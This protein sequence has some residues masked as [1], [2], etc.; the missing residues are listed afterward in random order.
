MNSKYFR[1]RTFKEYLVLPFKLLYRMLTFDYIWFINTLIMKSKL[2]YCGKDVLLK[3]GVIIEG[4]QFVSIG[5]K[6]QIGNYS[7]LKGGGN[8]QIGEWCQIASFVIIAT[9]NHNIDG[10]LYY[11]N[12]TCKDII[13]GNNVW[14]ASNAIILPGVKIGN[15]SVVAAGSVVSKNV[16]DNTVVGGVPAIKI[17]KVPEKNSD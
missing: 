15:N 4:S 5:Y 16:P 3:K 8:L 1:K 14:I 10:N 12:C 6:T 17:G 13:I 9:G 11:D 2:K 7:H